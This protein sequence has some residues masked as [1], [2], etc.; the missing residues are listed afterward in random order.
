ML[1]NSLQPTQYV[2]ATLLEVLDQSD[3]VSVFNPMYSTGVCVCHQTTQPQQEDPSVHCDDGVEYEKAKL[4]L[5]DTKV[6]Y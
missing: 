1:L 4:L 3:A 6:T 2:V 5:A